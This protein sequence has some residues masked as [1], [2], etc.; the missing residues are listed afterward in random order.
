MAHITTLHL[1]AD[2]DLLAR[3][4]DAET[5]APRWPLLVDRI[6]VALG[7]TWRINRLVAVAVIHEPH[8]PDRHPIGPRELVD[9]LTARVRPDDTVARIAPDT[10]VLL[11]N[12]LRRDDDAAKIVTRLLDNMQVIATVGLEVARVTDGALDLLERALGQADL[13]TG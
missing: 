12:E 11:L 4:V 6:Q 10:F 2:P 1:G 13:S 8:S 5:G 9:L 3:L 7:R